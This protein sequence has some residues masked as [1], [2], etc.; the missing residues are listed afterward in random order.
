MLWA[1]LDQ[2]GNLHVEATEPIEAYALKQ[3]D[4]QRAAGKAKLIVKTGQV[5]SLEALARIVKKDLV[6]FNQWK[7]EREK[8]TLV[9]DDEAMELAQ[10]K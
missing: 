4:K 3:W 5:L 7:K 9:T 8:M 1:S 10:I 2:D 6:Q